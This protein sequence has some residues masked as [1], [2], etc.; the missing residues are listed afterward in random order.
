MWGAFGA[1]HTAISTVWTSAGADSSSC[2]ITMLVDGGTSESFLD[3][4]IG[5]FVLLTLPNNRIT[6]GR[7][8]LDDIESI[9]PQ[10]TV[11]NASGHKLLN[12]FS[13]I[14]V[15]VLG[16]SLYSVTASTSVGVVKAIDPVRPRL[17]MRNEIVASSILPFLVLSHRRTEPDAFTTPMFI[18]TATEKRFRPSLCAITAGND[19]RRLWPLV[20]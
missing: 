4:S 17:Q 2:S 19:A 9:S 8:V 14:I 6:D 5:D 16:R 11:N 3:L 1:T 20:S 13:A 12:L 7:H 15:P 18:D 10:D